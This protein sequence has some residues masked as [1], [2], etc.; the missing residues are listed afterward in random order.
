MDPKRRWPLVVAELGWPSLIAL[1]IVTIVGIGGW[2]VIVL[3]GDKSW[4][5][6]IGIYL[7]SI[8]VANTLLTTLLFLSPFTKTKEKGTRLTLLVI[9][10]PV[11]LTLVVTALITPL[12]LTLDAAGD[13][14][15]A[16]GLIA[17]LGLL[18]VGATL[19]ALLAYLFF[20]YPVILL[21]RAIRPSTAH[22][23]SSKL[24]EGMNRRQL[25][26]AAVALPAIVVTAVLLTNVS[27]VGG[28]RTQRRR[29]DVVELFTLTGDPGAII[30][31]VLSVAV[32]VLAIVFAIRSRARS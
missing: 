28:T 17:A 4:D 1:G 25:I 14:I 9:L 12:G 31:L 27:D 5:E 26:A 2:V 8:L 29:A 23:A 11:L 16:H 18:G 32:L 7:G 13:D 19:C 6:Y 10:S 30:G 21:V 15:P 3:D 24:Y 20:V 22:T